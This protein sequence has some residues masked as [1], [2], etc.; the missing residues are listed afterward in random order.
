MADRSA[1]LHVPERCP[2]CGAFRLI[3]LE[4][5]VRADAAML[6]WCCMA[7][8]RSWPARDDEVQMPDAP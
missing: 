4:T 6:A 1:A 2:Y 7:C 8:N 3:K 5:T